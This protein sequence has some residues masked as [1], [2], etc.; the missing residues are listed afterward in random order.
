MK[1][2]EMTTEQTMV[3][4]ID[5]LLQKYTA[6]KRVTVKIMSYMTLM[7]V[8]HTNISSNSTMSK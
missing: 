6:L 8:L 1:L 2:R 3:I 5:I 7:Y 4:K